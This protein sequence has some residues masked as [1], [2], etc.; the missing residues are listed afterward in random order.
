RRQPADRAGAGA[1]PGQKRGAVDGEEA[2]AGGDAVVKFNYETGDRVDE[3]P[4]V[5]RPR[6]HTEALQLQE[7]ER[8]PPASRRKEVDVRHRTIALAIVKFLGEGGAF[9]RK[10]LEPSRR[11]H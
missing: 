8:V 9:Q 6:E 3:S 1:G 2:G 7:I 5:V 11:E 4:S 10:R